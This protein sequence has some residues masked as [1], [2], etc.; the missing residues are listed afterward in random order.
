MK[1]AKETISAILSLLKFGESFV[2]RKAACRGKE[3]EAASAACTSGDKGQYKLSPCLGQDVSDVR[4][5]LGWRRP[6]L[7]LC[8]ALGLPRRFWEWGRRQKRAPL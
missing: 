2:L 7:W 8:P 5:P 6:Q 1:G 3:A 4:W